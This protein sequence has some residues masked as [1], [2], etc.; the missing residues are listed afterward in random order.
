MGPTGPTKEEITN[1]D[2]GHDMS[3]EECTTIAQQFITN[4]LKD[5]G[6]AQFRNNT[7]CVKGYWNASPFQGLSVAFGWLQI[8]EV[9]G[10]NSFGGYVGFT[11]YQV[12]IK[13]G[14]VIRYCITDQDGLCLV[15]GKYE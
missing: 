15:H 12:L 1:A 2:Y 10:K 13:D 9:N 4:K 11:P 6:S 14:I 5:P 3:P 7:S 8:G